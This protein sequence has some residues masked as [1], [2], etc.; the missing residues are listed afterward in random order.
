MWGMSRDPLHAIARL[1]DPVRRRLYDVVASR[2]QPT[3]REAAADAVGIRRSLAAYHLDKLVDDGLLDAS[4]AR[5]GDRTGPGAGRTSK[6]YRRSRAEFA[7][8]VPPRDYER[9]ALLLAAALDHEQTGAAR[10][11]LLEGARRVGG[12]TVADDAAPAAE[13]SDPL[14][15]ALA[16]T[17][18]EPVL[19]D[20]GVIRLRN[21]PF[22][23][24]ATE[25]RDLICGMN[26]ALVQGMIDA[27]PP[28]GRAARLDRREQG[29]CVAVSL[30]AR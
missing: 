19:E 15:A 7:A 12:A 18:Y 10:A 8:S 24:L 3:S 2:S 23:R 13:G 11:G 9:A 17:G 28:A 6:L 5:T 14:M 25:H 22:H 21:C 20:G 26:L 16:R 1:A 27:L 4:Y 29:C 30:G